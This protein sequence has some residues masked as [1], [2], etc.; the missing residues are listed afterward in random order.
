FLAIAEGESGADP[1]RQA[2]VDIGEAQHIVA[3]AFDV[4]RLATQFFLLA[5]EP[6]TKETALAGG[7]VEA[8][9]VAIDSLA[10]LKPKFPLGLND[11]HIAFEHEIAD[12]VG[13]KRR[14]IVV[15]LGLEGI[16]SHGIEDELR[17]YLAAAGD[18]P[19]GPKQVLVAQPIDL[20]AR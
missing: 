5:I 9:L 2:G 7:E 4:G 17:R 15:S 13:M 8:G 10:K 12:P 20:L 1:D 14:V 16:V 18:N 11:V 3:G 19:F 6:E